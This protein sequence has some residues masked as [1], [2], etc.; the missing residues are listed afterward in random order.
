MYSNQGDVRQL[1]DALE[2]IILED[3]YKDLTIAEVAGVIALV[4]ARYLARCLK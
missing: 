3:R 2:A 1:E 4:Q